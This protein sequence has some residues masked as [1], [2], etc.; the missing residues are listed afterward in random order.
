[1]NILQEM[2]SI[3]GKFGLTSPILPDFTTACARNQAIKIQIWRVVLRL[4]VSLHGLGE[5]QAIDATGFSLRA[6]SL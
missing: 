5:V 4:S 3:L 1:M 6:V 2:T